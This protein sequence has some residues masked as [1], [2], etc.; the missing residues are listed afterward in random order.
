MFGNGKGDRFMH[1]CIRPTQYVKED[2]ND[3]FFK[4][5][6]RYFV[7]TKYAGVCEVSKEYYEKYM[8]AEK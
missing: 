3:T 2:K 6:D 8:G 4:I 5:N 1:E 7:R